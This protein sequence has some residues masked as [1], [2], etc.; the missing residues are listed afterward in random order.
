MWL[1]RAHVRKDAGLDALKPVLLPADDNKRV[2]VSHRMVWTLFP[3][4]PDAK[5]D[6]LWREEKP[7]HFILLSERKPKPGPLLDV[8]TRSFEP[9]LAAGQHLAFRLR[10]NPTIA[11][12]T[13]GKTRGVRHDVV[14]HALRPVT[15]GARAVP[16]NRELGWSAV[17]AETPP[18]LGA[19]LQWLQR[20]GERHGFSVDGAAAL[21]YATVRI[22]RD[23]AP[24]PRRQDIRFGAVDLDGVLTLN[25]PAAFLSAVCHGFGRAKAFG[26]GLMLIKRGRS[27]G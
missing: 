18:A 15:K 20:Q 5:R 10:A 7:G 17:D 6:F 21:S 24:Q 2:G 23:L 1:S 12:R 26:C 14:M 3:D 16:R 11:I 25:D 27:N 22:P 9:E 4:A 13:E 19:P 8:E